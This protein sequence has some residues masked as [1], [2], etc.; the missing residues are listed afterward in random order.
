VYVVPAVSLTFELTGIA[1]PEIG[2]DYDGHYADLDFYGTVNFSRNLGAQMGYRS[3]DVG[4]KVD[5]FT[6]TFLLK[7]L[8]FGVV[9]RY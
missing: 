2:G 1:I 8:Y 7:G 9:A 5:D 4:V 3:F 6:G